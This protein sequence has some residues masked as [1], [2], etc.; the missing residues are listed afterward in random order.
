MALAFWRGALRSRSAAMWPIPVVGAGI[1]AAHLPHWPAALAALMLAL[2]LGFAALWRAGI[3]LPRYLPPLVGAGAVA[4]VY[5]SFGYG[6]GQEPAVAF[7]LV[8]FWLKLWEVRAP[9]DWRTAGLTALFLLPTV[10]LRSQSP[11]VLIALIA[12][13]MLVLAAWQRLSWQEALGESAEGSAAA[14]LPVAW[15]ELT[16]AA[17][18]ALPLVALLFVLVPRVAQPLWGLPRDAAAARSGLSDTVRPGSLSELALS[19]EPAF[20][21]TFEGP[22]PIPAQRYYRALVLEVLEGNTWREGPTTSIA[23]STNPAS[24]QRLEGSTEPSAPGGFGVTALST[25]GDDSAATNPLSNAALISE[26][27]SYRYQLLLEPQPLPWLPTLEFTT[28]LHGSGRRQP[29]PPWLWRSQRPLLEKTLWHGEAVAATRW[30]EAL[31]PQ[32]QRVLTALPEGENPRTVA[33]GREIARRHADPEARLAALVAA[34]Q[35]AG[36]HYTLRPPLMTQHAADRVFF[37]DRRGFCEH[38]AHA[39]A[40]AARA[41]GLPAR[42]VI[43]Y[44]GGQYNPVN[45]TWVVRQADAHAW[46][47]VWVRGH[48]LRLDPTVWANPERLEQPVQTLLASEMPLLTR[49]LAQSPWLGQLRLYYWSWQFQWNRWVVGFDRERQRELWQRLGWRADREALWWLAAV[50]IVL[51]VLALATLWW[52]RQQ[53]APRNAVERHWQRL[54]RRLARLGLARAP[55]EP[56]AA[57]RDRVLAALAA[58]G[59]ETAALA[60]AFDAYHTYRFG[61]PTAVASVRHAIR[62]AVAALARTPGCSSCTRGHVPRTISATI[63]VDRN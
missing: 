61:E 10:L 44:Q 38:F 8:A 26:S 28:T 43:G 9:R 41:A 22:V 23:G 4:G 55:A 7:L 30:P 36:W 19:D 6:L 49:W 35:S 2:M 52:L 25:L 13:W 3:T 20:M 33:L 29:V 47:E 37:D 12:G 15:R 5:F 58:R 50:A 57:Y 34:A 1:T 27:A 24:P 59:C 51:A 14:V 18:L 32:R 53:N 60:A 62:Q 45:N 16:R 17:L 54:A 39:F 21:L 42:V 31:T 48:W 46:V 40:V 56:P 63:R 11:L